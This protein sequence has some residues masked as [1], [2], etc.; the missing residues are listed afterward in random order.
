M[1]AR[2]GIASP[3]RLRLPSCVEHRGRST[4]S[5]RP[6]LVDTSRVDH[7]KPPSDRDAP[8]RHGFMIV[9]APFSGKTSAYRVL[10]DA[11]SKLHAEYPNDP[12][13][14]DVVPFVMN[15][16]SVTMGQ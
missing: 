14:T 1:Q 4:W 15:P 5:E 9:G 8:R 11:L 13:W 12:R 3:R 10:A 6:R 7:L 2:L 16:K